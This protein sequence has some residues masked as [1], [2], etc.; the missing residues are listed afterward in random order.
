MTYYQ[1]HRAECQARAKAYY[2]AHREDVL[3]KARVRYAATR[4]ERRAMQ[5]AFYAK[6]MGSSSAEARGLGVGNAQ[7]DTMG[8]VPTITVEPK[9]LLAFMEDPGFVTL[10]HYYLSAEVLD[11]EV[12]GFGDLWWEGNRPM[13]RM[14][15]RVVLK[16]PHPRPTPPR[17]RREI[18]VPGRA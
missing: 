15:L 18:Q 13:F 8:D 5:R 1:E 4:D 6:R 17:M 14:R 10:S 7:G 9:S 3:A 16:R 11:G 12:G 2:W